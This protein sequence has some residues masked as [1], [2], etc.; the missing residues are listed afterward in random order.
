M[1]ITF[2]RKLTLGFVVCSLLISAIAFLFEYFGYF[3]LV[4]VAGGR[5]LFLAFFSIVF[6][7]LFGYS[8]GLYLIRHIRSLME[9]TSVMSKGDLRHKIEITSSDELGTLAMSFNRMMESL[10]QMLTEVKKVADAIYDSSMNLSATSNQMHE[11]TREISATVQN[12]AKGAG[13]Q[14]EMGMQTHRVTKEIAQS[15]EVIAQKAD[16]ANRLAQ[17]VFAKAQEGNQH[18]Q[19]AV[20]K[21]ADVAAK[22][23]NASKLVMGF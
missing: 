21:I 22:I 11:S 18:T 9:A 23:E 15:I 5:I 6:G 8:F 4:E 3:G 10:V 7:L 16:A 17:E 14:A 20:E 13:V 2:A 1:K 12:I 19:N